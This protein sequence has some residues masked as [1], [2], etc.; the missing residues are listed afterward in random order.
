[1][2]K[3]FALISI[4]VAGVIAFFISPV[5]AK[6]LVIGVSTPLSGAAAPT[7]LG[8]LRAFELGVDDINGAGGIKVG[9]ESYTIKLIVYDNKYDPKEAVSIANKLIFSDKVKFAATTGGTCVMAVNPLVNENKVFHMGYA[10]G[11]KKATNPKFPYTFRTIMEPIHGHS[12]LLPW[13]VKKYNVKSIAMTSTDD[14]TGIVQSEDLEVVAKRLSLNITDKAYAPRGTADFTPMLTKLIAKKPD[15]IDFGAWGGSD[16]PLACKQAKELGYKGVMIFSYTQSLPTFL[17]VAPNFMEGVLFYG[18]FADDP[19]PL[20]TK[21][22]KAYEAKYKQKFDPLVWRNSD[23]LYIAKKA[24][25]IAGK[26]DPTAV[27]DAMP[28]VRIEGVF[29][30]TRVGGKTYYGN[31][32]QMLFPVPL[33]T[34]DSSKKKLIEL[35]RGEM[36][37]D[38]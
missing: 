14:E 37:A 7:G 8:L 9:K 20:A 35:N 1:M 11:G 31:D 18:I 15:A 21:F 34:W 16:G 38:Y 2:G 24:I 36:P 10:Y 3:R 12:A 29:G 28:K 22:A 26:L 33:T 32:C 6:D 4:L 27:R 30:K 13:I 17:K 5:Q 19:T 25:E 23:V